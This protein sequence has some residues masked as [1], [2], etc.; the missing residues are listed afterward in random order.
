MYSS[1]AVL[2]PQIHNQAIAPSDLHIWIVCLSCM[3]LL[4]FFWHVMFC[5][6]M[7]VLNTSCVMLQ[8]V[9]CRA[10]KIVSK[11]RRGKTVDQ[12][13]WHIMKNYYWVSCLQTYRQHT[14]VTL[15]V[16]CSGDKNSYFFMFDW[17]PMTQRLSVQ[18]L[19]NR[20]LQSSTWWSSFQIIVQ[21]RQA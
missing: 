21:I 4:E 12:L 17:R 7:Y 8:A 16:P 11:L 10:L 19:N 13:K 9:I 20:Q 1:S 3:L 5:T 15:Q 2:L 6:Y 14:A 18:F